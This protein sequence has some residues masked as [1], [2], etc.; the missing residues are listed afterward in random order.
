MCL[1]ASATST[2]NEILY[3]AGIR[4][5]HR[6]SGLRRRELAQ[7]LTA[8]RH[9]LAGSTARRQ[10]KFRLVVTRMVDLASFR[11]RQEVYNRAG[12]PCRSCCTPIRRIVVS[13]RGTFQ[14]RDMPK[15]GSRCQVLGFQVSD[16]PQPRNLFR[17]RG[18]CPLHPQRDERTIHRL[19]SLFALLS[20]GF[21]LQKEQGSH[22]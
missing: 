14:V 21:L 12:E 11:V 15:T 7:L 8:M 13:G 3:K 16:P 1:P 6:A 20:P 2:L 9:V 5:R 10:L 17:M 19:G 18:L 22:V 4:P